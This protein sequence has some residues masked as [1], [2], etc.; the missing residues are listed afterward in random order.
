MI[1]TDQQIDYISINL[2]FYG[3]KSDELRDDV[4]DHICTYIEN[5]QTNDFNTAYNEVIQRFGGYAAMAVLERDTYLLTTFKKNA[6]RQKLVYLFGFIAAFLILIGMLFK[7]MHWP[8]ANII[9]FTG[10]LVLIFLYLP[11]I[12]YHRYKISQQKGIPG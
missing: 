2:K 11:V 9:F 3:I 5:K 4:I 12:F 10:S 1:L 7:F 6:V 8:Y